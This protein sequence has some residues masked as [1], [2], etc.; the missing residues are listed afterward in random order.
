MPVRY[1]VAN[2][3]VEE[4]AGQAAVERGPLVYCC[5]TADVSVE[6]L[7]DLYLDPEGHTELTAQQI[8]GR[9]VTAIELDGYCVNREGYNRNALYQ[10]LRQTGMEKVKI[11]MG[12][13]GIWRDADLVS[14]TCQDS[15][16]KRNDFIKR[17]EN[18]SV[19]R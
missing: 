5:E 19:R 17:E 12:Q 11:R 7:D 9:T 1:T 18:R 2:T 16:N 6:S 4:T 14:D 10:T 8:E 3:M 13:S 15:E